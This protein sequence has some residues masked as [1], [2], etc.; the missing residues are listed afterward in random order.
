MNCETVR[1]LLSAE[2]DG[3]LDLRQSLEIETHAADCPG[4][5]QERE[6][7]RALRQAFHFAAPPLRFA[8]P[9]ELREAIGLSLREAAGLATEELPKPVRKTPRRWPSW[10]PRFDWRW[11]LLPPV[12]VAALLAVAL[13]VPGM[14]RWSPAARSG[15]AL[16]REAIASHVRSLLAEHLLDVVSSD[17][18]TVKPWFNGRLDFAPPVT[19]FVAAGFPLA[20]GR[21]DYLDGRPVAALVYRHDKHVINLFVQ[22]AVASEATAAAWPPQAVAREGFHLLLWTERDLSFCAV[23][24]LN[25]LDLRRFA[26][27]V[28]QSYR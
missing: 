6:R 12:A 14:S 8:A 9:A 10:T 4:C 3:E 24:D 7:L 5:A 11:L 22:P 13:L 17:Q 28:R 18:H 26:E 23:S 16:A 19:D 1:A 25:E 20:G 21:L 15:D 27:T 2:L